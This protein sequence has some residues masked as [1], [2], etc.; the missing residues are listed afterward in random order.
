MSHFF[1]P[2]IRK[3]HM[4]PKKTSSVIDEAVNES[5]WG[6]EAALSAITGLTP[7]RD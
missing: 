7:K 2:R 4:S 5:A 3:S 6:N 1:T